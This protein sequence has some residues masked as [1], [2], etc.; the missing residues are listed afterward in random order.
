MIRYF[1]DKVEE[2][3]SMLSDL[4]K[5]GVCIW[6]VGEHSVN[7]LRY[8]N[9]YKKIA[10][11][12]DKRG[13]ESFFGYEVK[14]PETVE[15]SKI[16]YIVISSY[17]YQNDILKEIEDLKFH[18]KV[19][20][21][22]TEKD[23]GDFYFLPKKGCQDFFFEGDYSS[24]EEAEKSSIGY[25]N[26]DILKKV[27]EATE[28]VVCGEAAFERDSVLFYEPEYNYKIVTLFA[29]IANKKSKVNV[30]DF[31][32]AL[33]SEFWKNKYLLDKF[34]V[35]YSW[36]VVE[37]Q[38]YVQLA[39]ERKFDTRLRFFEQIEEIEDSVDIVLLS[40]VLQ[41]LPNY[42]EILKKLLKLG[43]EYIL[44]DRQC[45]S[46]KSRIC[47]QHV[48]ENIYKASYPLQIPGEEELVSQ[49]NDKYNL[50]SVFKSDVD[51]EKHYVD[52]KCFFYKGYLF[53]RR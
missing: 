38:N 18:G 51:A 40:S 37:Q 22:Y 42:Q 36:N 2:I 16:D 21:L 17:Q 29:L 32:G 34:N 47:V 23:E 52:G 46:E 14:K 53:E 31:G 50:V 28:K 12:I 26:E 30:L 41:Y 7:L 43:A 33:A 4:P 6:G 27:F 39:N 25:D 3:N 44:V 10:F 5:N 20:T 49:F 1:E 13:G 15:F 48:G 24:W 35:D 45:V 11:F 8:T 9:I 19:I